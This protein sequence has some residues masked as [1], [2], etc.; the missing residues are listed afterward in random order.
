MFN[1][2]LDKYK[3]SVCETEKIEQIDDRFYTQV[4]DELERD[5]KDKGTHVKSIAEAKGD[6]D[7]V[8]SIYIRLR[9]KALHDDF[10]Q[11]VML[12]NLKKEKGKHNQ[13]KSETILFKERYTIFKHFQKEIINKGFNKPW[14][15]PYNEYKKNGTYYIGY[16]YPSLKLQLLDKN[17]KMALNLDI[18]PYLRK[19]YPDIDW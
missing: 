9:A 4:A 3:E 6:K 19:Q 16:L 13:Q 17:K 5:F 2:I 12:E 11:K 18:K 15:L 1:S 14:Y 8:E 7:K 10:Y